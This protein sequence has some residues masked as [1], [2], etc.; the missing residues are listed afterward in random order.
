MPVLLF[1]P[2]GKP[3]YLY[4]P[5]HSIHSWI[6]HNQGLRKS[7]LRSSW[8]RFINC[9]AGRAVSLGCP[10]PHAVLPHFFAHIVCF[11]LAPSVL[12]NPLDAEGSVTPTK[13]RVVPTP[14]RT[15]LTPWGQSPGQSLCAGHT[16]TA[17]APAEL[18]GH[19]AAA[20]GRVSAPTCSCLR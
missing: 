18:R 1:L 16:V 4:S 15:P 10:H 13:G 12:G 11:I 5:W 6:L 3:I 8:G 14:A 2:C 7:G 9:G 20:H 17:A 19:L